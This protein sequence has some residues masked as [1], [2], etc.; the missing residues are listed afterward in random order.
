MNETLLL[1]CINRPTRSYKAHDMTFRPT[2]CIRVCVRESMCLCMCIERKS[3][4]ILVEWQTNSQDSM[5]NMWMYMLVW[6]RHTYTGN[7]HMRTCISICNPPHVHQ[8]LSLRC[9][10]PSS[11]SLS[12][13]FTS[14]CMLCYATQSFHT[15]R[16][17]YSVSPNTRCSIPNIVCSNIDVEI[18][19]VIHSIVIRSHHLQLIKIYFYRC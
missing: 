11:S 4:L 12:S 8:C 1:V 3:N 10:S 15:L 6:I 18:V 17:T 9:A 19:R 14:I 7:K 16:E 2:A 13:P 5:A